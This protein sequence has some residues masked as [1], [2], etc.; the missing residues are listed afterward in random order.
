MCLGDEHLERGGRN[1]RC[2]ASRE[3]NVSPPHDG[4]LWFIN[5]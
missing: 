1:K 2:G 5:V 3:T 4:T